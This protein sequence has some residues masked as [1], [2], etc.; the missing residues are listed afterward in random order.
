MALPVLAL[1]GRTNVG[2]S[3]LF[4]RLTGRRDALVADAPGLTR[5]RRYGRGVFNGRAFLVIDS[6]GL[7]PGSR[8]PLA[9]AMAE[10]THRA[11]D[12]ADALLFMVD[13]RAGLTLADHAI[14]ETLRPILRGRPLWLAI[15]KAEGRLQEG[16][17][18]EFFELGLGTLAPLSALHGQGIESLLED[19]FAR[20]K[21]PEEQEEGAGAESAGATDSPRAIRLVVVGRPNCGKSTLINAWLGQERM[22]VSPIAGTTRDA[23][24]THWVHEGQAY[25]LIDTAGIRK[26]ASVTQAI[27]KF[28]VVKTLQAIEQSDV[29]LLLL[30]AESGI[31]EQ[32]AH[33]AGYLHQAGRALVIAANKWDAVKNAERLERRQTMRERLNFLQYARW[34]EISALK[35][36][37]LGTLWPSIRQAWDAAQIHLSTSQLTRAVRA[38][39]EQLAPARAAGLRPALRYAHQGGSAPPLIVI[40][41]SRLDHVTAAYR[42]YLERALRRRFDLVGTPLLLE[43]KS[44]INPYA[45]RVSR[46]TTKRSVRLAR[47]GRSG[48]SQATGKRRST[49]GAR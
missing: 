17:F 34:H 25:E 40:H 31:G 12:E 33:I 15:N 10:Q 27:E 43:F 38:A 20:L 22:V 45:G 48:R 49:A 19:V 29:A 6:G 26:K 37:G 14:A 8:D 24:A 3:T 28:S 11:I 41:G 23:I 13:A 4:N 5:D 35:H 36:E 16:A 32:D 18:P 44:S 7:M 46:P 1:I 30:D 21:P 2:K 42:R 47:S 9:E 39:V